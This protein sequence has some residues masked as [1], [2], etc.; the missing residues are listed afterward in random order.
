MMQAVG[1]VVF[2]LGGVI[3]EDDFKRVFDA[4]ADAAGVPMAKI[5]ERFRPDAAYERAALAGL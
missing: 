5:R 2:D 3:Q 1:A 4:W